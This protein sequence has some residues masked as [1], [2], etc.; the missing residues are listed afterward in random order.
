MAPRLL[1]DLDVGVAAAVVVQQVRPQVVGLVVRREE[2][3]GWV[4]RVARRLQVVELIFGHKD[5]IEANVFLNQIETSSTVA[6]HC[7]RLVATGAEPHDEDVR[8]WITTDVHAT[9]CSITCG[10]T[11]DRSKMTT[12][13][14]VPASDRSQD[15]GAEGPT[16]HVC[17]D[18]RNRASVGLATLASPR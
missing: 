16:D 4:E 10:L 15:H 6:A 8:R 7:G 3:K 18:R 9:N 11:K 17:P 13:S 1:D 2:S 5:N 12:Q 14:R